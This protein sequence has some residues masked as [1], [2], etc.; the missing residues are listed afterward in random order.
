MT[1]FVVGST[2]A[3]SFPNESRSYD[4]TRRAIR[5]WGYEGALE[6]A[7]L[8]TEQAL[9]HIQPGAAADEEGLLR[10]FD[11]N[12]ALIYATASKVYARSGKRSY[13][14]TASDF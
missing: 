10:A 6:R 4:S 9:R 8:I 12:R 5:F 3:L 2:A 11:L 7:F 13:G 1:R 14:L